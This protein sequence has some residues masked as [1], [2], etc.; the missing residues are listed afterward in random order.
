MNIPCYT[1]YMENAI[2]PTAE[3]MPIIM[4]E[5]GKWS[6][7]LVWGKTV[8]FF[9]IDNDHS[10]ENPLENESAQGTIYSFSHRHGNFIGYDKEDMIEDLLKNK[11]AV[12]LSY[13][14]HGNS[15]W[16]V[17]EAPTPPGV[18]FQWDGVR[19]AGLWVPDEEVLDNIGDVQGEE[20]RTK[21]LAYAAGVVEQFTA[22]CNGEVYGYEIE[23]YDLKEDEDGNNILSRSYYSS[24]QDAETDS[25]SGYYGWDDFTKEVESS[26]RAEF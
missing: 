18:E 21:L 7:A 3:Q 11:E 9:K 20:R 14:E 23:R 4:P 26:V 10:P 19:F 24:M 5:L 22:W 1:E 6:K 8:V 17:A 15:L 2:A 25:C 13:F 12:R 16:M